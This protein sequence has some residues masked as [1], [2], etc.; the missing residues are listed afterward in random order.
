MKGNAANEPELQGQHRVPQVYL[1]Q[2]GYQQNDEWWVSV[3]KKGNETT[4][5]VLIETFTKETN[6]FDLPFQDFKIRR[7]FEK[8]SSRLESNYRTIISNLHHQKQLTKRDRDFLCHFI[9]N[10]MCRSIPFRQFIDDLLRT[11]DTRDKFLNEITLLRGNII[12]IKEVLS[13]IPI[14]FQLNL[15]IL[16]LMEHMVTVFRKFHQVVIQN[17][18]G[19]G[20][21]TTD[22]P[23]VIDKQGHH[24]WIIPFEAEIYFPLSR[25]FCIFMFCNQSEI[26]ANP[27]RNLKI[28]KINKIDFK[29]FNRINHKI[30]INHSE[31]MIMPVPLENY[32]VTENAMNW[33]P[34]EH[35]IFQWNWEG[36]SSNVYRITKNGE[37]RILEQFSFIDFDTNDFFDLR[38]GETEHTSFDAFWIVAL[39]VGKWYMRH[40]VFIHEDFKSIIKESL[41]N[42]DISG[43]QDVEKRAIKKWK[44]L[45]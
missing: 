5:N 22:N 31:Y 3:Y 14:N 15:V 6:I 7:Y 18:D 35:L 2:F 8:T 12:R 33:L 44:E 42:L 21:Q 4:D 26:K 11:S 36:G 41:I 19:L 32:D 23:V 40:P 1:K 10:M 38:Q 39:S 13:K 24:E 34:K 30:T 25:D 16:P 37:Q 45:I 17:Y 9:P 28:D 27:L 20:W 43:L 29:P